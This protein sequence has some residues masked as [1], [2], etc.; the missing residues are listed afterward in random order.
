MMIFNKLKTG[1]LVLA[2]GTALIAGTVTASAQNF[3]MAS[4]GQA[5]PTT[6]FSIAVSR[7]SRRTMAT[8]HS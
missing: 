5:S 7:S 6:V 8:A 2:T 1:A 3:R 4:L